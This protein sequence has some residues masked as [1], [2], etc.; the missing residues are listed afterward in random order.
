VGA[1]ASASRAV[2]RSP[3]P[4][5]LPHAIVLKK[6]GNNSEERGMA[7]VQAKLDS[8][9]DG[10]P[11]TAPGGFQQPPGRP[12]SVA[13]SV[14]DL[15]TLV[16]LACRAP[17]AVLAF[18]TSDSQWGSIAYGLGDQRRADA[19]MIFDLVAESP[20]PVEFPDLLLHAPDCPVAG[21]PHHMRW[22]YGVAVAPQNE[23]SNVVLVV[24]DRLLRQLSGREESSLSVGSRQIGRTLSASRWKVEECDL[25][26]VPPATSGKS[27][28]RRGPAEAAAPG[29]QG[30]P[31][32]L[33]SHDVATMFD[34]TERTVINW[35]HTGKL[36][37]I[38]TMGGHLRFRPDEVMRYLAGS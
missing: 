20:S 37:S 23:R 18:R 29:Q 19:W 38:R 22:A 14:V 27:H 6:R 4:D 1:A 13:E 9:G 8:Y 15:L 32:L 5:P 2:L 11:R 31:R 34:V 21:S 12:P 7:E 36:P 30:T 17:A 16:A 26:L 35:A 25:E 24:M 28:G 10:R 33:R 3:N